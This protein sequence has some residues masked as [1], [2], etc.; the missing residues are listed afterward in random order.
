M[1]HFVVFTMRWVKVRWINATLDT[2]I[3]I[4]EFLGTP[5]IVLVSDLGYE[6]FSICLI[7][8]SVDSREGEC[9]AAFGRADLEEP[10]AAIFVYYGGILEA[11]FKNCFADGELQLF[12]EPGEHL[13]KLELTLLV[14]GARM[15]LF[16]VL[17]EGNW[18]PRKLELTLLIADA[19][20]S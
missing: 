10:K 13:R 5:E 15:H 20:A 18:C 14:T 8:Q 12:R 17:S 3:K 6:V 7:E 11:N 1:G 2:F 9:L 19:R 4:P 16:R